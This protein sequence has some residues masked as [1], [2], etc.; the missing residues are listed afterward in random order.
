[1]RFLNEFAGTQWPV[2]GS[3]RRENAFAPNSPAS[4]R[5]LRQENCCDA[6]DAVRTSCAIA[7]MQ[8]PGDNGGRNVSPR[9][10]FGCGTFRE[11]VRRVRRGELPS[12]S[13]SH[14]ELFMMDMMSGG[15]MIGMGLIWLLVIVFLVLGIAASIKYLRS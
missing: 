12:S 13:R 8:H 14:P 9:H 7:F 4:L 10:S 5:E 3:Q 6:S 11:S 2:T 1:M 15:M